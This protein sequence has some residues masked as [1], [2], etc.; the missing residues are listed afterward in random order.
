MDNGVSRWWKKSTTSSAPMLITYHL[1]LWLPPL[2]RSL[3][4][5]PQSRST[6]VMW[7]CHSQSH[8]QKS[9]CCD[10]AEVVVD[11]DGRSH[12]QRYARV[13]TS[14]A[15]A[16]RE[17]HANA[18]AT[19]EYQCSRYAR[20]LFPHSNEGNGALLTQKSSPLQCGPKDLK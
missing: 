4:S 7:C 11:N 17:Y 20:V 1:R 8:C 10:V 18:R 3:A 14:K 16:T 13:P 2:L 5:H 12:Y 6:A 15:R 19:R 9:D